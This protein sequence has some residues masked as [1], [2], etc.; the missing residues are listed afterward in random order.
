MRPADSCLGIQDGIA[1][2]SYPLGALAALRPPVPH[3]CERAF[4]RDVQCETQILAGERG[5]AVTEV[6][7]EVGVAA[8]GTV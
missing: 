5:D 1:G 4:A 8:Q 2:W 6:P 7:T 3:L